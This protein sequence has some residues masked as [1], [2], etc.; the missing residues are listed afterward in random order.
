MIEKYN[1][2]DFEKNALTGKGFMKYGPGYSDEEDLGL[3]YE[4]EDESVYGSEGAASSGASGEAEEDSDKV[5]GVSVNG[6]NL[7]TCSIEDSLAYSINNLGKVDIHYMADISGVSEDEVLKIHGGKTIYQRPERYVAN[8]D[9]YGDWVLEVEYLKGNLNELLK[10]ATVYNDTYHGRFDANIRLIK[11]RMPDPPGFYDIHTRLG[12]SWIYGKYIGQFIKWLMKMPYSPKVTK[13]EGKWKIDSW[14]QP[15][16]V[17]NRYQ[18]GTTRMSAMKIIEHT[19]NASSIKVRDEEQDDTTATGVRMVVNQAETL[20][21]INKQQLILDKFQE[22]LRSDEQIMKELQQAYSDI[23]AF[24]TP[25]YDGSLLSLSDVSDE[26]A[27]YKHQKDAAMRIIM[28]KN[29]VLCHDVGS[30]KTFCYIVALHE[31]HR[32]GISTRN[33]VV[34]PN[35]TFAGT[36]ALHK[37]IYP[38]D[39]ILEISPADFKVGEREETIRRIKQEEFVAIYIAYSKFDMLTM[40][41]KY[42]IKRLQEEIH[43]AD[44][45]ARNAVEAWVRSAYYSKVDRLERRMEKLVEDYFPDE[46]GCFDELG[47]TTLVVD[48]CQNYKN[49]SIETR[50]DNVVGMHTAGSKKANLLMD[51]VRLIQQNGGRIVF[52]TG[53][54]LTNSIA[55]LFVFQSYLQPSVLK[56]CSIATFG[57][58]VNTFGSITT[59]F[60]VDVNSQNYRYVSRISHYYNLPELMGVFTDVC[61]FYHI[62]EEELNLPEFNGFKDIVVKPTEYHKKF[63]NLIVKRTDAVRKG[64]V[65]QKKDNILR[66]V[67]DGRKAA[68]DI[69]LVDP[70][71]VVSE[72]ECKAGA[73]AREVARIYEE[74]P[75]T[76][77]IIFCD[78]STPKAEFNVYDE[79]KRFLLLRGIPDEDIAFIHDGTTEAKKNKLLRDLDKGK[80]RIMLGSTERLGVGV[81]VQEHLIALHHLDAPW[82]PSD[83]TQREGRLIRQGNLNKEVFEYR[84]ITENSFDAYVWQILENKQHFIGSFLSG[85]MSEFHRSESEIDAIMLDCAEVKAL[86]VGNPLIRER[87]VTGNMLERARISQRERYRQLYELREKLGTFPAAINEMEKKINLVEGDISY[88]QKHKQTLTR[89][90]RVMYGEGLLKALQANFNN[91]HEKVYGSYMRFGI[92][93]PANMTEDEPYLILQ[94]GGGARYRVD[95]KDKTAENVTQALDGVFAGFSRRHKALNKRLLELFSQQK[96]T[97]QEISRGNKFDD[98]VDSLKKRLVELDAELENDNDD[99]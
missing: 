55:D 62:G 56:G 45:M 47:I 14:F 77:Q 36:V 34:V 74:Y 61:D 35:S 23:Y 93:F 42:A 66:I 76:S 10:V 58:W 84:Y 91:D 99:E 96:E 5:P 41:R 18:Y 39:K 4:D 6:I 86:A 97:E 40:T 50:L 2:D 16:E 20:N 12:A 48:E 67:T 7:G 19:L 63:N 32:M 28:S 94:R 53:T 72:D 69:R 26:V 57:E 43:E 1:E 70:G 83:L 73:C 13:S 71:A 31:M 90:K 52:A 8:H 89:E 38:D 51:K 54:L 11:R 3:I 33:M 37:K 60:E 78:Y 24:A 15:M 46:R 49:V 29:T 65:R 68:L 87:I 88:Y 64:K 75:G 85:S 25:H 80:I 44:L 21:A 27:L 79:V 92:Y 17:I 59:N 30:G 98:E 82:R 81:N 9:E 22:W 95:M